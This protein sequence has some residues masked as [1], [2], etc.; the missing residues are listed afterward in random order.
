M[1]YVSR[2]SG[3]MASAIATERAIQRYGRRRVKIWI[4]DTSWE[5]ADLYRFVRDLMR[6][7]GGKLHIYRDGRT[8]KDIGDEYKIIPNSRMAPCTAELK[9]LP[10]ERWLWTLPKPVTILSGLGWNEPHRINRLLRY[11]R[12]NG[13]PRPPQGFSRRIHGV[14]EE[15]PLLW[16]PIDT[17]PSAEVIRSWGI[18]PPRAYAEGF[19]HNN[20][21]GRCFKQGMA[22]WMRLRAARPE[23]FAEM[24]E[25][26]ASRRALGGPRASAAILRERR[27][28]TSR[29]ITLAELEG[30]EVPPPMFYD[31]DFSSCFCTEQ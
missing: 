26:E 14:Y 17:R 18:E 9:I 23:R 24:R 21:G 7:W 25:W 11:H 15:F 4:A 20:C 12:H 2:L 27:G 1:Y 22:E 16:R 5:D 28:G 31:E 3:G 13:K 10:F 8:P 29:P 19:P 30:R 6:R